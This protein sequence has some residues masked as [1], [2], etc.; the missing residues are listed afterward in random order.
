M[1]RKIKSE[2]SESVVIVVIEKH[3]LQWN[4]G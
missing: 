3:T 2:Q 1:F 4:Y